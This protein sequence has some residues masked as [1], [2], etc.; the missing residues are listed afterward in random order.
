MDDSLPWLIIHADRSY[1]K[2]FAQHFGERMRRVWLRLEPILA[3]IRAQRALEHVESAGGKVN[4]H[5][6]RRATAGWNRTIAARS[7]ARSELEQGPMLV[8][9]GP[10]AATAAGVLGCN[11]A[12]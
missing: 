1:R 2:G 3:H 4:V 8:Q 7:A 11:C 5:D 12:G 10:A 6:V 9:R